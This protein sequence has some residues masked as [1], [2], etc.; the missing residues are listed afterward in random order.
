MLIFII[1]A[2]GRAFRSIRL[3]A[4]VFLQAVQ[5][6]PSSAAARWQKYRRRF[7]GMPLQSLP[8]H[9]LQGIAVWLETKLLFL[10]ANK[11]N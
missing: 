2:A 8:H 5:G 3:A 1:W 6:L 7:A 10:D 4:A 11:S 9:L